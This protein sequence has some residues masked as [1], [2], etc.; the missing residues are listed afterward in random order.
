M[1]AF[2]VLYAAIA[3][4]GSTLPVS[5][6]WATR[7]AMAAFLAIGLW[8]NPPYPFSFENNL[9]M[10]DFV[11]LQESAAQYLDEH[12]KNALIASAWP[13]TDEL[14]RPE[15]GYVSHKLNVEQID[16][17]RLDSLLTLQSRRPDVLVVYCRVWGLD[18]HFHPWPWLSRYLERV[19][20]VSRQATAEQIRDALG[21]TP[22]IR[23]A[24]RGQW[25]EIYLPQSSFARR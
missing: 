1:P 16:D 13:F 22:V 2:P 20:G 18:D 9:A 8:W 19:W 6:R 3:A 7:C 4:A 23:W 5:W 17:F 11:S 15:F 25:I 21:F 10:M 12:A 14:R 24:K